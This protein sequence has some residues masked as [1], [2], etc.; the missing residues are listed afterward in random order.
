[1]FRQ[2]CAGIARSP[3]AELQNRRE[4]LRAQN[5]IESI[6]EVEFDDQ[7]FLLRGLCC[8]EARRQHSRFETQALPHPNLTDR[9]KVSGH[10]ADGLFRQGLRRKSS[11]DFPARNG[12]KVAVDFFEC[13]KARAKQEWADGFWNVTVGDAGRCRGEGVEKNRP[14]SRHAHLQHLG[15]EAARP[16]RA[17]S[18]EAVETFPGQS[19][20]DVY[21]LLLASVWCRRF[22]V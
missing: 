22:R 20:L 16:R 8:E 9:K 7:L 17:S 15:G 19:G 1:V 6:A 4:N 10:V 14:T 21:R 11:Q 13:E 5:R 18:R 3:W 12:T 2:R